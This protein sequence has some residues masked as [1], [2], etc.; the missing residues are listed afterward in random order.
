MAGLYHVS[1]WSFYNRY[2][3]QQPFFYILVSIIIHK[4]EPRIIHVKLETKTGTNWLD[5]FGGEAKW[6]NKNIIQFDKKESQQVKMY[7]NE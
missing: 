6:I 1:T 7:C 4:E 5:K 2:S 3:T